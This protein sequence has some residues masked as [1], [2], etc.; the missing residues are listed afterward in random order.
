MRAGFPLGL[1]YAAAGAFSF[2][3]MSAFAKLLGGRIPTQEIILARGLVTVIMT[4]FALRQAGLSPWGEGE[5]PL[6]LLRGL[7]GYG[8]LSCFLWAVVR[9]PLADTTVI[10]FTNPVFTALLA[11]LFL[12]ELLRG[13]EAILALLA[14]SGVV[15]IARPEFL[16]GHTSGLD[17]LA[18]RIHRQQIILAN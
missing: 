4:W 9:L 1:R 6:L 17:P 5:R 15:I 18:A 11:A 2:S 12:G 3:I 8:A 14:L 7:L 10:H 13:G 16:F